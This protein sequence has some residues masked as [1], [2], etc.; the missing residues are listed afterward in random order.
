[1]QTSAVGYCYGRPKHQATDIGRS[2]VLAAPLRS[3]N[4]RLALIVVFRS[5]KWLPGTSLYRVLITRRQGAD[6]VVVVSPFSLR[7]MPT[8][9]TLYSSSLFHQNEYVPV[10]KQTENNKL[11]NLTININSQHIQHDEVGNT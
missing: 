1:M 9:I 2:V 3:V 8:R 10:A 4:R 7:V 6:T 5:G 11:I